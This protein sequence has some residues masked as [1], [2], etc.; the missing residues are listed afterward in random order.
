MITVVGATGTVGSEVVR[1]LVEAG[2][3]PRVF[4]RAPVAP[5]RLFGPDVDVVIGDLD[6]PSTVVDALRGVDRVFLVTTQS[7]RQV[8]WERAVV[9]AAADAGVDH[10]VKVSVF[11]ADAGSSLQI[12]RQHARAEQVLLESGVGATILRPVFFMQNLF[13]ML[14]HGTVVTAARD[15][16]V[17][18]VDA[19]DVAAV[20]VAS[21]TTGV[22]AGMTYTLTGP[23]ALTFDD[24]A[25]T[26]AEHAKRA[27]SHRRVP[28]D[29]VQQAVQATGAP[30]WF[31]ADMAL[32]HD[33]L[34][35][36]Y[37]DVVTNDV[38]AATSRPPRTLAEFARDH[39]DV[40]RRAWDSSPPPS[41]Y[42]SGSNA[43]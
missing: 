15:G 18:L 1:L 11:R 6:R 3:R 28:P 9:H 27:V 5:H 20:A 36:G 39:A 40:L 26:F 2:E 8:D 42:T 43:G 21:L 29:A 7:A 19:R 25:R 35:D 38:R 22:P 33:M 16:R 34:A 13:R 30:V 41:A 32:L 23:E 37:E 12:A 4:A 17:A 10:V 14:R 24:V 31:A